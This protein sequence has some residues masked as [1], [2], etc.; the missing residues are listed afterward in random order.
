MADAPP[1]PVC[2]LVPEGQ[3]GTARVVTDPGQGVGAVR[4]DGLYAVVSAISYHPSDDVG[5]HG[6]ADARAP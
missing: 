5:H 1:R 2:V 4:E 6:D 3:P